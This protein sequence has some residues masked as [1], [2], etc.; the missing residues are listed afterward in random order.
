M[1]SV[2]ACTTP[3]SSAR[4]ASRASAFSVVITRS[5]SAT[6]SAG[7]ASRFTAVEITPRP[8]GLVSTSA[9]PARALRLREHA[10]GVD[11]ADDGEAVLRFGVVD[12]MT[13][14]D[15]RARGAH[16]VG[17]AVE[18]AREQLERQPLARPGDEVERE[19][20]RAAHRVHVGER[21]GGGDAAPVVG[22]VD[23][24][25]EEVGG[26]D[27]REVV[28]QAVHRGVVRGVEPDEQVGV[29]RRVAE[30]AHE[31]EHGAQV[32]GGE[33]AGAAGAV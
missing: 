9:S 6:S 21:V 10:V 1:T 16:H 8:I 12:G 18:H 17:A 26:H 3:G 29:L 30:A 5:P 31:A 13:A 32:G 14:A 2:A 15:Q 19:Q 24:R 4:A 11:G 25:R 33:L 23:D 22:V 7:A 28:A 20:R 27:D